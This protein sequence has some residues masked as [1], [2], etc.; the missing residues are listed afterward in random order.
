MNLA[1][2]DPNTEDLPEVIETYLEDGIA[3]TSAFNRHGSLLAVGCNDGRVVV[4]DF[5]TR[6]IART[7]NG[8]IE[9][10]TSVCWSRNGRKLLS[11][12]VDWNVILW[13][14]ANSE[15]IRVYKFDGPVTSARIHPRNDDL[16]VACPLHSVPVLINT[17]HDEADGNTSARKP[18]LPESEAGSSGN[19]G[20]GLESGMTMAFAHKG[21]QMYIGTQSGKIFIIDSKTLKQVDSEM[22][23]EDNR[24][25]ICPIKSIEFSRDGKNFL[26]NSVDRILR[27]FQTDSK[28]LLHELQELVERTQ[29]KTCGFSNRGNYVIAGSAQDAQHRIFIFDLETGLPRIIEG[30]KEGVLDVTWHPRRPI[31]ASTSTHGVVYIWAVQRTENWSAFAPDFKELE[32]NVEYIEREDEFDHV[33]ENQIVKQ[34]TEGESVHVDIT[35]VEEVHFYS[36]D[37]EPIED[38]LVYLPITITEDGGDMG[39]SARDD[40]DAEDDGYD[41]SSKRAA[42]GSASSSS[43]RPKKVGGVKDS[44]RRR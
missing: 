11:A 32:E 16:F 25:I 8:H 17:T 27:I 1:L 44:R 24:P 2:L 21:E 31:I 30:P 6:G 29:W 34:K 33:D 15:R 5:D 18:L 4:W 22:A 3:V 43:K 36:S 23:S 39:D 20:K 41:A 14:V 7:L 19:K 42:N 26:V 35:T 37:E 9:T 13:D 12:S 38:E 28:A 40:D 10:V